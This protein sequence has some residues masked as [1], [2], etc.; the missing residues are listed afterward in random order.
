MAEPA[1]IPAG[2]CSPI[3][4]TTHTPLGSERVT[5]TKAAGA[6]DGTSGKG[7]KVGLDET[8]ACFVAEQPRPAVVREQQVAIVELGVLPDERRE[9]QL[10]ASLNEVSDDPR[11]GDREGLV[12]L[13]AVARRL[14]ELPDALRALD[15][16][17]SVTAPRVRVGDADVI[18]VGER[19]KRV[20]LEAAEELGVGQMSIRGVFGHHISV[21]AVPYDLVLY[22]RVRTSAEDR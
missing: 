1:A 7:E 22:G 10:R 9:R 13:P 21:R 14:G 19:L 18:A 6:K 15:R 8:N 12:V 20:L 11:P 16:H 5:P 17:L 4:V 3:A 2:P